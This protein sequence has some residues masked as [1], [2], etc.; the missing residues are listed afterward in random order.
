[1]TPVSRS[2]SS[3]HTSTSL[4]SSIGTVLSASINVLYKYALF[5]AYGARVFVFCVCSPTACSRECVR[6]VNRLW[7]VFGKR[8]ASVRVGRKGRDG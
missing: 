1:M 7:V 5:L 6:P 2:E 4:L 3:G 8:E